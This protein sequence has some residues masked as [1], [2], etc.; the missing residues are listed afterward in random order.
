MA[1]FINNVIIRTERE[2]G[3]E[4]L[5]EEVEN[6][7]YMKPEKCKWKVKEVEFLEVIIGPERIKIEEK[8]VKGVLDWLTPK[9]GEDIQ[10]Y[11]TCDVTPTTNPKYKNKSKSKKT[12]NIKSIIFNSDIL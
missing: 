4:E 1:S 8:K 9:G 5:V 12:K 2:E 6:D 7:L 3:H 10:W 11:M